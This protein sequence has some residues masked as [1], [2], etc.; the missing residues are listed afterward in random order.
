MLLSVGLGTMMNSLLLGS[1][2]VSTLSLYLLESIGEG[3][4]N[5]LGVPIGIATLSGA[6]LMIRLGSRLIVGPMFGEASDRIGHGLTINILFVG[7]ILGMATLGLSV[8]PV[9]ST[10]AV[11][12]CF[13]SAS[14]LRVV[15]TTEA[16][17][18]A[19]SKRGGE[20]YTM[21][22]FTNWVDLGSALGPLL[23]YTL[24]LG[25]PFRKIYLGSSVLLLT[26]TFL[27]NVMRQDAHERAPERNTFCLRTA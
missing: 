2:L 19:A 20:R 18:L 4:L 1:L 15:L 3:G 5:V 27:R 9:T 7:G 10:L 26:Y 17:N 16:S 11:V 13:V 24:R 23:A 12:L 14:G 6:L 22:A 8:S 25:V 21:S